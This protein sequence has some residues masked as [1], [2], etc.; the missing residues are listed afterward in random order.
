[1]RTSSRLRAVAVGA[2]LTVAITGCGQDDEPEVTPEA[3]DE[4]QNQDGPD[5]DGDGE[6][7]TFNEADVESRAG[8]DP[9]PRGRR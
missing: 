7:L 3:Q 5:V 6:E 4:Q 9:S 1:M 2:A 8:D